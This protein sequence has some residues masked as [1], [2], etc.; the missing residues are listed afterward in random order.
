MH[1]DKVVKIFRLNTKVINRKKEKKYR[2]VLIN[3]FYVKT[4]NIRTEKT[5]EIIEPFNR[6]IC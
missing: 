4:V 5:N 6:K 2:K 3:L 1:I